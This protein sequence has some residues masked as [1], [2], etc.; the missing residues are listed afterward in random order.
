MEVITVYLPETLRVC[1]S[2]LSGLETTL[3]MLYISKSTSIPT[4]NGPEE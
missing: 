1:L 2:V 4:L 3:I